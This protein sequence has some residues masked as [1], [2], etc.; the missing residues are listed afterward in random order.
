MK[1]KK[2]QHI[3]GFSVSQKKVIVVKKCKTKKSKRRVTITIILYKIHN[4]C[5]YFYINKH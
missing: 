2:N 5:Q 3:V 1:K 4:K